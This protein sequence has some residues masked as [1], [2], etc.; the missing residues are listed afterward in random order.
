M[1]GFR[2]ER[3]RREGRERSREIGLK[4]K[5]LEEKVRRPLIL[6]LFLHFPYLLHSGPYLGRSRPV[7]FSRKE[8]I[9]ND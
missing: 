3:R 2:G 4:V 1:M 8:L 5:D 9:P 6:A 7:T